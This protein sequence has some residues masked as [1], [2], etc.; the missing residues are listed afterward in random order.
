MNLSE[1]QKEIGYFKPENNYNKYIYRM[2]KEVEDG[3]SY[4]S[5]NGLSIML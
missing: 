1:P 3:Y 2:V 5:I 4:T